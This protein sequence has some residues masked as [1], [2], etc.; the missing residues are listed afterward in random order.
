MPRNPG[1]LGAPGLPGS[2][3]FR[4]ALETAWSPARLTARNPGIRPVFDFVLPILMMAVPVFLIV[5]LALLFG[6][7]L[8]GS[9]GGMADGSCGKCGRSGDEVHEHRADVSTGPVNS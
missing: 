7:R 5:T 3:F 9:C 2:V 4:G 8:S 1:R 6:R